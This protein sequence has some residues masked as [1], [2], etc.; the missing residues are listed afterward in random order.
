MKKK[1][2]QERARKPR[3]KRCWYEIG[4]VPVF[5]RWDRYEEAYL[6]TVYFS[7]WCVEQVGTTW[8]DIFKCLH[9]DYRWD[10]ARIRDYN[11]GLCS[12]FYRWAEANGVKGRR[13][14]LYPDGE[15]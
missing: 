12:D 8:E 7:D 14:F 9:D 11:N 13:V 3:R 1:S 5:K 15:W 6:P 10:L 4:T 2:V